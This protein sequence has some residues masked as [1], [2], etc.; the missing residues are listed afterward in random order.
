MTSPEMVRREPPELSDG[1]VLLRGLRADDLPAVIEQCNDPQMARFTT[2][3]QPYGR[4][5][6][7][8]FLAAVTAS[9]RD[10]SPSASRCWS[11]EVVDPAAP[12][13]RGAWAG[14]VE[15]HFVN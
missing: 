14:S 6:A 10:D 7:E 8:G 3:P 13:G 2:V 12:D 9:W 4:A 5:E 11:I 15:Y 1:V